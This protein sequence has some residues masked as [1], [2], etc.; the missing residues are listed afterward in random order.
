MMSRAAPIHWDTVA[1]SGWTAVGS[2]A[3]V[4]VVVVAMVVV[5]DISVLSRSIG[6]CCV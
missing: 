5:A 4:A 1:G 2:G 3:V 6:D